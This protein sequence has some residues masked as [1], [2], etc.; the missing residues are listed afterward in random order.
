VALA[1]L[2][3]G[4]QEARYLG[5]FT[6]A[7]IPMEEEPDPDVMTVPPN[8]TITLPY[9]T[10]TDEEQA[11]LMRAEEKAGYEVPFVRFGD[12]T[13]EIE[14][15]VKSLDTQPINATV[16]MDGSNPYGDYDAAAVM[17]GEDE[18]PPPSL[19]SDFKRL[20]PGQSFTGVF[21]EQDLREAAID[22]DTIVRWP[23]MTMMDD[24]EMMAMMLSPEEAALNTATAAVLNSSRDTKVDCSTGMCS[25]I[26][27]GTRP[28]GQL[29]NTPALTVILMKLQCDGAAALDFTVRLIDR[30]GRVSD[31]D[32]VVGNVMPPAMAGMGQMP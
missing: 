7:A 18:A 27:M 13:I 23:D 19:L 17:V 32:P 1:V 26:G 5:P 9:K 10:P 22:L 11:E 28:E 15:V 31:A 16:S 29:K 6:V 12:V 24:P 30:N 14:Y 4:C 25:G 21:T 20:E 3:A 8:A 2:Q